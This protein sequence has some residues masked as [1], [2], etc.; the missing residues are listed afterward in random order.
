MENLSLISAF[1]L[2]HFEFLCW[3]VCVLFIIDSHL[4]FFLIWGESEPNFCFLARQT[5]WLMWGCY[6][7]PT[8][9][10]LFSQFLSLGTK[11]SLIVFLHLGGSLT[12]KGKKR[13]SFHLSSR[14]K[15]RVFALQLYIWI[16][17]NSNLL[18]AVREVSLTSTF[19][20]FHLWVFMFLCLCVVNSCTTPTAQ[21]VIFR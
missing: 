10:Y 11:E 3:Y 9:V 14:E 19:S 20:V 8:S 15:S 7:Y 6:C 2:E 1:L 18:G 16:Q 4:P 13:L 12:T 21:V 5:F 17:R